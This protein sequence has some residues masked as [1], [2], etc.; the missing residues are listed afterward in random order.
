MDPLTFSGSNDT[1]RTKNDAVCGA[2]ELLKLL[3]DLFFG[4]FMSCLDANAAEYFIRMMV[5]M[6]S[7]MVMVM[8]VMLVLVVIFIM[9]VVMMMLVLI[10]IV[11]IIV[12]MV[13]M[14]V[15]VFIVI[16][17]IVM[18]VVFMLMFILIIVMMVLMM[19]MSAFLAGFMMVS[20]FRADTGCLKQFVFELGL[21]FH[22]LKDK[23]T[24]QLVPG[25]CDQHCLIIVFTYQLNCLGKFLFTDILGTAQ[26]DRLGVFDLIVKEFTEILHIHLAFRR[27]NNRNEIIDSDIGILSNVLDSLDNI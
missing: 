18:M 20:A 7:V 2:I 22:R 16:I 21:L 13:M 26:N 11:V 12:V 10:V 9:V 8:M 19:I 15:L 25:S 27:V 17:V 4:K 1:L 14:L 6:V 3:R 23:F 24:C 5:V